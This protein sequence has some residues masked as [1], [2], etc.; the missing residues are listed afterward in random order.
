[1]YFSYGRLV[2][3]FPIAKWITIKGLK[4]E[5]R[6]RLPACQLAWALEKV[7]LSAEQLEEIQLLKLGCTTRL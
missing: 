1:M 6:T 4:P 5:M 7:T 2:D 3:I